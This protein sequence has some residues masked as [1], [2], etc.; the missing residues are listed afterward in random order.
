MFEVTF[1]ISDCFLSALSSSDAQTAVGK[2]STQGGQRGALIVLG[3][4]RLRVE[5]VTAV[6]VSYGTVNYGYFSLACS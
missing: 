5:L 1:N 4:L 2:D 3:R 6:R